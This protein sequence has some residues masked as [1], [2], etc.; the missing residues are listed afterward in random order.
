VTHEGFFNNPE[1]RFEF[2][3]ADAFLALSSLP[4][5]SVDCIITSPPY[6][7]LREYDVSTKQDE[8]GNE[9]SYDDYVKILTKIFSECKRVLKKDGSLWL[10]IGDKYHNKRLMGIPWRVALSLMDDGWILRND[11]IWDQMKGTQSAKDRLRDIYEHIFHFVKSPKYYYN[12][13]AIRIKPQKYP[14]KNGDSMI[15]AT[16][17]SGKRYRQQIENSKTL[18]AEEKN[19]AIQALNNTI[20]EMANG[21][22]VD[23]RMTIR[24]EQ[25]TFH[26]N[27]EKVS[28]RAKELSIKGYYVLK[29]SAKGHLPPDIWRITPEDTQRRD[30]HYAVFPEELLRIPTLATCPENGIILDPFS[31]TGSAI[32]NAVKLNRRG[33]GIDLSECY[34]N[35]AKKRLEEICQKKH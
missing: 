24:G 18:S 4:G 1:K 3:T 20:T 14:T 16:G 13:E 15:S 22:I 30:E 10:N 2:I 9:E 12:S 26:S 35:I 17:V 8:I 6:W 11:V 32:A 33:I 19:N 28:G 31:G 34:N 21:D 7:Q 25:R 5:E 27:S 29:M 23:F